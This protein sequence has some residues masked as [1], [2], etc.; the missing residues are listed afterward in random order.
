[1]AA[2]RPIRFDVLVD[3]L[4]QLILHRRS[5]ALLL[6]ACC[7]AVDVEPRERITR[8]HGLVRWNMPRLLTTFLDSPAFLTR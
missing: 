8:D 5:T 3:H 7:Q 1:M 6:E 4:S 2:E